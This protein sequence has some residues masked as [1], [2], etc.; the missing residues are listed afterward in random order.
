M[1]LC[2][3]NLS[4]VLVQI[5]RYKS[6][7]RIYEYVEYEYIFSTTIH[8]ERISINQSKSF[9]PRKYV[10][11]A[12]DI[13]CSYSKILSLY[14][15]TFYMNNKSIIRNSVIIFISFVFLCDNNISLNSI[16]FV[17]RPCKNDSNG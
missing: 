16:Y 3:S 14:V 13:G 15:F 1:L 10:S 17:L 5:N 2:L 6:P 7:T 11:H 12:Y 8:V 9:L 4:F